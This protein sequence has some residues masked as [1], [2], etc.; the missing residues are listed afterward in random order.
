M[1]RT[2]EDRSRVDSR[3]WFDGEAAS[4]SHELIEQIDFDDSIDAANIAKVLRGR[5]D[6][7]D[8]VGARGRWQ[9]YMATRSWLRP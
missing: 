1:Q 4:E 3:V 6:V 8:S 2:A 7:D 5:F 9:E